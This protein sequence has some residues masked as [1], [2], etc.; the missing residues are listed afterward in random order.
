MN[1]RARE[2]ILSRVRD[3]LRA[4]AL[5]GSE[6]VERPLS[7][8]SM[9]GREEL[10][11]QF[12]GELENLDVICYREREEGGIQERVRALVSGRTV[13]AWEADSLPY[14]LGDVVRSGKSISGSA[15]KE[16]KER[17]E[18]GLTGVQA[19]IAATGSL[20]VYSSDA[21]PRTASLL[22][23]THIAVVRP[24]DVV[25][26]LE[27]FI[28]RVDPRNPGSPNI[29]VITGPSR[30]ADIELSI[31]LGVHGPGELV[32]VIGP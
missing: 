25:P 23:P 7:P 18:I 32:V 26:D 20:V 19:A 1:D 6:P 16:V 13:L 9:S 21:Q 11:E 30:T 24:Y 31:T 17:A 28:S 15:S 29:T 8:V 27:T 14:G 5:P 2:A 3:A 22:P 12:I 10:I 4:I